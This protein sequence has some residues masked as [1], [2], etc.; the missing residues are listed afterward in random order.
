MNF[1]LINFVGNIDD[2]YALIKD[3]TPTSP[4]EYILK[5]VILT[6]IGQEHD[7]VRIKNTDDDKIIIIISLSNN[8]A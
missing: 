4:S 2:G 1:L 8:L 7:S 3:M 5:A 6:L